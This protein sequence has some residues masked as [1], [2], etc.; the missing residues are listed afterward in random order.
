MNKNFDQVVNWLMMF[1]LSLIWGSSFIL[2]KFGLRSFTY[3]QV[4]GLRMFI[5]FIALLPFALYHIRKITK[6]NFLSLIIVGFIGNC[7]P[8][9]LFTFAETHIDS[10]LAG[11]L[12]AMTPFFTLIIGAVLYQTK[13][14]RS[15]IWG[16]SVGLV[17]AILLVLTDS[18]G[19]SGEVN[20]W[21]LFV[22]LATLMYGVNINHVKIKLSK[23]NG[24]QIAS[25]S[26]LLI[27]PVVI[28]YLLFS[29]LPVSFA[30]PDA[31]R[32]FIYI[33]LLGFLGS[34]FAVV[35]VNYLIQRSS[36]LFASS[37]TYL[38]PV[39][40]IAWGMF[41]NEQLGIVQY[42][43]VGFVL[44]GVYLVNKKSRKNEFVTKK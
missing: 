16:V 4:A 17:G 3:G 38:M 9:F 43:G 23:L 28:I 2:M 35:I 41:D 25:L 1:V 7:I 15:G 29:N 21:A 10:S 14:R 5:A 22:V 19:F 13:I 34:A 40:A 27:G 11:I 31:Y 12:N 33:F 8:A 26:F 24:I 42:F 32:D 6:E 39:V 36:A 20:A 37:V 44:I 18:N 30:K